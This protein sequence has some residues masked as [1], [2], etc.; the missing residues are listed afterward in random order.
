MKIELRNLKFAYD[1]HDQ[2]LFKEVNLN[3]D[4]QWKLGLIGRNG[5][6]KTTLL[7]LLMKKLPYQG[8]ILHQMEFVYFPITIKNKEQLTYF[9]IDE[10]MPIEQWKLEREFQLLNLD[11]EFL[12][13]PFNQLSGG[14]QTKALLAALFCDDTSYPLIDEP[15]NH[16]DSKSRRQI[17]S[18]LM[19]KKG[20]IVVSHD[21]QFMNL[22]TDH[23]LAI[24]RDQL[25]L[26]QGNFTTYETQKGLRDVFEKEQNER[27]KKEIERLKNTSREKADWSQAKENAERDASQKARAARMMKKSKNLERRM[28]TK[29]EE[30]SSLLKNIENIKSLFINSKTSHR[31]PVLRVENFT[32]GYGAS[33]LFQ[34]I[35][36]EIFQGEQLALIGPKG[37]GKS[38]LLKYILMNRFS[39]T[40]SG[41]VLL[42]LNLSKS[43]IRQSYEDNSGLLK[44]FAYQ[45]LIDYT[46]L[47]NNLRILGVDRDV[48][49][50]PIELMSMGQKKKVELAAS[51]GEPAEF[52]I[53]DEPLNYLDVF[54]QKQIEEMLI[55]Y[56]PTVLFVEHD[57]AFISN[58]ASKVVELIPF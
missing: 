17:A 39:G 52:Y 53:W 26:Y 43:Q 49:N 46:L 40:M 29:I 32:L 5:R 7:N 14:E 1:Y 24:E 42:P 12:W 8:E 36:F 35:T 54:N 3:I 48:F 33:P 28:N 18:Y 11:S 16:L 22:V 51:L 55:K 56:K 41:D 21:R 4:S 44:D 19:K 27:L 58:V 38:T 45:R 30:K 57:E 13:K 34:P 25:K 10:V 37:S 20:Y 2:P 23:I 6:G 50:I 15:T 31:N 9:A 47:L